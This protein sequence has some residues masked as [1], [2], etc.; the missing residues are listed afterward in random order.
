M[1]TVKLAG[2]SIGIDN[3]FDYIEKYARDYLTDEPPI[4]TVSVSDT[5]LE[6]E[7]AMSDDEHTPGYLESIAAYR[8]IAERMPEFDAVVFHGAVLSHGGNAYA[9]TA[10]SGV[11]KT[12]HTKLWISTLK[13]VHYL[14]GDKPI[15]RLIEGVP[16]AFGT[17]WR[18]KEGYGVNESAPLRAIALL[19]RGEK[20]TAEV[21]EAKDGAMRLMSQIYIS[22]N[23]MTVALTMRVADRIARAVRFV[24][25]RCNMEPEA[26]I[27]A[28]EAMIQ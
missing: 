12:T 13:D 16:Y 18:G 4:F 3:R 19:N 24:E 17:P 10:R 14:N 22:R 8:K 1:I 20:N 9:F 21:I 11:G 15:I 27:V 26:A 25:L 28:S 6:R 7:A 2:L 5:E 23:P